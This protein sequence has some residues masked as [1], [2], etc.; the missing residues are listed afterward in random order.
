MPRALIATDSALRLGA[1]RRQ[2]FECRDR[3]HGYP[4]TRLLSQAIML[5]D[6]RSESAMESL[7]RGVVIEARLPIPDLQ[8]EVRGA[9]GTWYRADLAWLAS[10]VILEVDGRVKYDET[11]ALWKE[12]LRHDDLRDAGFIVVRTTRAQLLQRPSPTV[13]QLHR[14]LR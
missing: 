9:S 5:A 2:M 1:D 4:G 12:K 3:L 10:G 6:G 11:D 7:A 13:A 14:L 8:V